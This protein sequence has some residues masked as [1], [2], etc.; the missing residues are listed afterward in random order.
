MKNPFLIFKRVDINLKE[1]WWHRL[2]VVLYITL[3]LAVAGLASIEHFENNELV[4]E[5]SFNITII[6]AWGIIFPYVQ[7][8][9]PRLRRN[10]TTLIDQKECHKMLQNVF[11]KNHRFL[12]L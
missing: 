7:V 5:Q 3:L 1:K 4:S 8:T 11:L 6:K 12:V 10:N 9:F 2:F